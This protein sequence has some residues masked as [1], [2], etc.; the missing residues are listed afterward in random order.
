MACWRR[1]VAEARGGAEGHVGQSLRL[2]C[3]RGKDGA[4]S[5]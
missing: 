4:D 3:P 1:C 5:E 2:A